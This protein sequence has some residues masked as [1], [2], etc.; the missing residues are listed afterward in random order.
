MY[1]V[2]KDIISAVLEAQRSSLPVDSIVVPGTDERVH[3]PSGSQCWDMAKLSKIKRQFT[4]YTKSR[5]AT[6]EEDVSKLASM[7]VQYL[8][9]SLIHHES[10]D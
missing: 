1:R 3:L 8:N 6:S 10:S 9:S 5:G 7:F 2:T 4:A